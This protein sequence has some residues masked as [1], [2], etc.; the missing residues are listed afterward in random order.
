MSPPLRA[1]SK[2]VQRGQDIDLNS[3]PTKASAAVVRSQAYGSSA[4]RERYQRERERVRRALVGAG[5][6]LDEFREA[7]AAALNEVLGAGPSD[8]IMDELFATAAAA[9]H[10]IPGGAEAFEDFLARRKP[11]A[12]IR[13]WRSRV[14]VLARRAHIPVR[15]RVRLFRRVVRRAPRRRQRRQT[16]LRSRGPPD[17]PPAP[18]FASRPTRQLR[19][20]VVGGS[21]GR[22]ARLPTAVSAG[23]RPF[24]PIPLLTKSPTR[25][26]TLPS[27]GVIS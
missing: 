14:D 6:A 7:F 10:L 18:R 1:H 3:L 17:A 16:R 20:A 27:K 15:R 5:V 8:A 13:R 2:A 22:D 12:R 4:E 19:P 21:G 26:T 25:W 23:D 24:D 11:N 9:A